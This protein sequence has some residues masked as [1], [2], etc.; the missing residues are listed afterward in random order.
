M[1]EIDT[2]YFK[3]NTA[4]AQ[5]C[6]LNVRPANP[7]FPALP[8]A[9]DPAGPGSEEGRKEGGE[10]RGEKKGGEKRGEKEGGE[11]EEGDRVGRRILEG[12]PI[13]F[14]VQAVRHVTFFPK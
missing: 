9:N 8:I 13:G 5:L 3:K 11:K 6:F 2:F 12:R 7:K 4:S 10:K 1:K 14:G